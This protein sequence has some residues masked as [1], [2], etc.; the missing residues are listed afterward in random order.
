MT[1]LLAAFNILQNCA[2]EIVI[3]GVRKLFCY[4][5]VM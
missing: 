4:T 1:C 2:N 3:L 5:F